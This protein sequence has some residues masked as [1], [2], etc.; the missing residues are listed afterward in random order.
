MGGGPDDDK[1]GE[2]HDPFLPPPEEPAQIPPEE[3][4]PP[5]ARTAPDS[6]PAPSVA[7]F[8]VN[9]TESKALVSWDNAAYGTQGVHVQVDDDADW[10]NGFWWDI[11]SPIENTREIP[12][13]GGRPMNTAQPPFRRLALMPGETYRV[14]IYS[15]EWARVGPEVSFIAS[16][17]VA[18]DALSLSCS[19]TPSEPTNSDTVLW[20]VSVSGGAAPFTYEWSGTD[21]LSGTS[22]SVS[23]TYT[24]TGTK[25]GVVAVSSADGNRETCTDSLFVWPP[26]GIV[27]EP[28][29]AGTESK[30]DISWRLAEFAGDAGFFVDIDN[31]GSWDNGFWNKFVPAGT[32]STIA[33]DGFSPSAGAL[34]SLAF[35]G[36]SDY[37]ARVY[38]IAG[39]RHTPTNI[40]NAA[41]CFVPPPP[42]PLPAQ[43]P[44]PAPFI[45]PLSD[46]SFYAAPSSVSSGGRTELIWF[47]T[48]TT[49]CSIDQGIGSVSAADSETVRPRET[50]TY[51]L[52]CDTVAGGSIFAQ[53]TVQVR[54]T[55]AFQEIAPRRLWPFLPTPRTP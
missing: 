35:S 41:S 23:K 45:P 7:P 50:T 33:P 44:P 19:G 9:G 38:Y 29:C 42:T 49:S 48:N 21:G 28:F 47:T 36:G 52:V 11:A 6:F 1:G 55:P 46:I 8:C 17:A 14:R 30:A 27:A 18:P 22:G 31:D 54:S 20:S 3:S 4:S 32:N 53:A 24:T 37:W 5:P 34:G 26:E 13:D 39:V 51:T 43:E 10:G 15:L 16:C 12:D 2:A 25:E 40:F